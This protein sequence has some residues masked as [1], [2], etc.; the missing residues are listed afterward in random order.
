MKRLTM[1]L[2]MAGGILGGQ[3]FA[4][5][6]AFSYSGRLSDGG[7]AASGG[8]DLRAILYNAEA[9]G[10]QVGVVVT[11]LN[12]TVSGG[13]F[14]TDFDF[15]GGVFDGQRRWLEIGIRPAGNSVFTTLNPR[16][17][18]SAA[19]YAL[20]ALTP[21]GPAGAKGDK[22]DAG[23]PGA[24]GDKGDAGP[25]GA[26]GDAGPVG[27][28]GAQGIPGIPGTPGTPGAKGDPGSQGNVGLQ[29]QPGPAGPAGPAGVPGSVDA[30]SRQG[31]AG[32]GS[33]T[34][35]VGTTDA[36]PFVLRAGNQQAI[37]LEGEVSGVRIIAGRG[38][39]ISVLSTNSSILGGRENAIGEAAHESG[40]AG[41]LQNNIR[42]DQRSAFIGGGARNTINA[43][44]QHGFIGGGRD[45]AIGTNS[46]ISLVV[47]GGENRIGNN[48]DGGLMVGGFRNDVLG[49]SNPNRREIAPVLIG[50]SDNTIGLE[51]SWAVILGGDNNGIGTN[52]ASAVVAG[53]TN[54]IV[55]NNCGFSFVAGRRGRVN[56]PGS[57]V[58]ADSQNVSYGSSAEDSFNVRASGGMYLNTD[59]SMF[60]GSATRQMI[61]LWSDRYGIGVQDSTFYSRTDSNGAFS[62]FRGGTHVNTANN[63]G[64]GGVEMM[65]LNSGGLRV[66]GTF[67][68]AS[69]RNAKQDFRA[70]DSESVLAKVAAMPISEWSYKEDPAV[71]HVGPMAQDFRAAFPLGEDDRHIAMVDADGVAFAAIQGLNRKVEA[72]SAELKTRDARIEKLESELAELRSLV[73]KA[74]A[75]QTEAHP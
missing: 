64:A 27:S 5:E 32:T 37:R 33:F 41:G 54:N 8:F 22:G 7:G 74:V 3:V 16:Q 39:S 14:R 75:H 66:N 69:D 52:C 20:Y 6:T 62:W 46:V 43:D 17:P 50:G 1:L 2:V 65:R 44:N 67:V 19:P 71:R 73:L 56:H 57:F 40:I 68:S 21:A 31:N 26:K 49:S 58:W 72:Q 36:A 34:N 10:A 4:Q 55:A 30:W 25:P 18:I 15:G 63:P 24:K 35:F 9:G 38:N 13:S 47:G 12:V 60:F 51:S 53:G 28:V 29:G 42:K 70:V 59:T 48:V 11:N 23:S 45:N 61:N